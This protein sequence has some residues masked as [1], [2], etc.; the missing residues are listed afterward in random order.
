LDR[1]LVIGLYAMTIVLQPLR[2]LFI[3]STAQS[4]GWNLSSALGMVQLATVTMLSLVAAAVLLAR[5]AR[6]RP[7]HR[8]ALGA[9]YGYGICAVIF[10]PLVAW[11]FKIHSFEEEAI[12]DSIQVI[13]VGVMPVVVLIAFLFGGFR[14]TAELEALGAWLGEPEGTRT[15]IQVALATAL[16]DPTLVVRY[17]SGELRG[18]V[19]AAGLIVSGRSGETG[20]AH[21]E[22][23]LSGA[24]VASIDYDG[25]LLRD[26]HEIERAASLVALALERERLSAELRASRQAVIASRQRLV[27]A[28]DAERRRISRDLHDGLQARLVFIGIEAQRIATA[29]AV[30]VGQRATALRGQIDQAAAEL[31]AIVHELMPPA[32][33]Q[34]GVT[35]AVEELVEAMPIP[36][37]L[38]AALSVR[39][40]KTAEL[41]AYLVVAEA[42]T[43]V[44]KHSGA[45]RCTVSLH[46]DADSGQLHIR[47]ADNGNGRAPRTMST[48]RPGAGLA[49]IADRIAA[50]GGVSGLERKPEGGTALWAQIPYES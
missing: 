40:G 41:T 37:R 19:S 43:N 6:A 47:V 2:Y 27:G 10:V 33:L 4:P 9:V 31:R 48:G 50:V 3:P 26:P 30:E 29:P 36:T 12:R 32:L 45:T 13:S 46:T 22:I 25:N 18:W 5:L 8:P 28:A 23:S 34:L 42:L 35:G 20:H 16:G 1:L 14:R 11:A 21:Y 49:G 39:I 15:P 44:V 7:E 24:P 38:E 17:W